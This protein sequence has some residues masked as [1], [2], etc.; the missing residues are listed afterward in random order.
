MDIKIASQ[1]SKSDIQI[2]PAGNKS[3]FGYRGK[4]LRYAVYKAEYNQKWQP[5]EEKELKELCDKHGLLPEQFLNPNDNPNRKWTY[6]LVRFEL[7]MA[8]PEFPEF[9]IGKWR[10]GTHPDEIES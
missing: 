1:G 10:P 2:R 5:V 9:F 4:K 6:A 7:A 8:H 3:R